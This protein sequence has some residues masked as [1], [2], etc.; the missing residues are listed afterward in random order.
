MIRICSENEIPSTLMFTYVIP[1]AIFL[2]CISFSA[3]MCLQTLSNCSKLFSLSRKIGLACSKTFYW[4]VIDFVFTLDKNLGHQVLNA[5]EKGVIKN[6]LSQES[7]KNLFSHHREF[8]ERSEESKNLYSI[9]EEISKENGH[10]PK[11]MAK[12]NPQIVWTLP[13]MHAAVN[14]NKFGLWSL[15]YILG[16]EA[17]A[18]NGQQKSSINLI[19]EKS[20][21]D[22]SLLRNCNIAS[23]YII[24]IA[25]QMYGEHALYKAIKLSDLQLLKILIANGYNIDETDKNRNTP[26]HI[27]AMEGHLECLKYLIDNKADVNAKDKQG[28][29][30]LHVSANRGHLKCLKYLID[31]KTDVNLKDNDCHTPL[32]HS[33]LE[34]HL[35]CMKYLIDKKADVNVKNRKGLTLLHIFSINLI[36]EKS[37]NDGILLRNC[38]FVSRYV[39][40][41]ATQMYGEHALHR[42]TKLG[43]I[44]LMKIL[45]AM[46]IILMKQTIIKTHPF[47]Y[48]PL[49]MI[50]IA[51]KF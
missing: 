4:F 28:R 46:A 18:L 16:C 40:K 48:L 1:I 42:A 19:I 10:N 15:M 3:S 50:F 30:P 25:T 47:T 26:L 51:L 44:Q 29:T 20:K 11:E 6:V 39:I 45:I 27:S 36:I 22:G 5:L 41:I 24:K 23:R 37:K 33:W 9:L 17:G 14:N 49:E 8:F 32:H 35:E 31:N 13:L 21:N 2:L 43:D 7:F 34:G 12:E 38:N